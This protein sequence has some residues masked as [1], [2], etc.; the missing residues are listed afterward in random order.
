V[1]W[2]HGL[3]YVLLSPGKRIPYPDRYDTVPEL[4]EP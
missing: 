3:R 1:W 2:I 4:W